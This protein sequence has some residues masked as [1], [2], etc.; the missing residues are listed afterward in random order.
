MA[1]VLCI[2]CAQRVKPSSILAAPGS[3][4]RHD[5]STHAFVSGIQ[6]CFFCRYVAVLPQISAHYAANIEA[7]S[8]MS[9]YSNDAL[10]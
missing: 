5:S 3:T 4:G 1:I 7:I 6:R 9:K 2:F 10:L 8:A